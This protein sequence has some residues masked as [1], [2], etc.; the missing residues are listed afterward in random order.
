MTRPKSALPGAGA[1]AAI[2]AV[3]G[4]ATAGLASHASAGALAAAL[5]D[6]HVL[7]VA[8]FTVLQ[9]G[10]STVL[11]V[12][13]ALP[14]ARAAARRGDLVLVRAM[15][16]LASLAFVTPVVI[17]VFGIV[18]VH[19]RAGWLPAALSW[20]GLETGSYVYGLT[21][22]LIA[23]V[24]FNMPFA[25]RNMARALDTVAPETWRLAS[26]LGFT[27]AQIFR[28]VEWPALRQVLFPT[29][30]VIF[31]LCFT[32]FAVVLTLGGGPR[33]TI[34]EVAI[35]QALRFE[36]DIDRAVALALVQ[37]A[38]A[39]LIAGA[40]A[41]AARSI[42]VEPPAGALHARPDLNLPSQR[43][44]DAGA[45][46]LA[47]LVFVLPLAGIVV[48]SL[49]A[50]TTGR[51]ADA[52]LWR[53]AGWSATIAVSAGLCSLLIGLGL[54]HAVRELGPRMGRRHA[55][56]ALEAAGSVILVT[57][58]VL[59]GAG[60]FLALRGQVDV[61]ASA[62]VLVI[63]VNAI[64]ALPFVLRFLGPDMRR[65]ALV[66]DRLCAS[67]G[68]AGLARWRLIDW[69][70]IRPAAA[71]ALAVATTI[72]AGDLGVIALFGSPDTTT[73][74]LLVYQRMGAY[75]MA[76]AAV[77]VAVLMALATGLIVVIERVVG[78][79]RRA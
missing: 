25:A 12:I 8:G 72:A 71:T 42:P 76:D 20:L 65:T 29:A 9:A 5:G 23:H 56:A 64:A 3:V 38:L 45:L 62:P 59:L 26:Q 68:I 43:L 1:L 49:A 50:L 54:L 28:L 19:G 10:L 7:R 33:A 66:H 69:P 46:A 44:A 75:R 53:A 27:Q 36:F 77:G 21:G 78:G 51:L 15:M 6:P 11:S 30:A 35:Y 79:R 58:P 67:L 14:F 24:F 37:I 4:T 32:S 47:A 74:P 55:A 73:L 63:A 40:V 13:L 17:G 18:Q 48:P 52:A 61:F 34:L 70:A 57:P 22:I 41:S 39:G 60:L 2:C 16:A 31:A